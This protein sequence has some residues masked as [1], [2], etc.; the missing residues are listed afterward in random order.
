MPYPL[1]GGADAVARVV[2]QSLSERINA[3]VIVENR[4][5]AATNL[6]TDAT[7]RATPDGYTIRSRHQQSGDQPAALSEQYRGAGTGLKMAVTSF[8]R[9]RLIGFL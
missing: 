9:S 7:A 6:G 5:G 3:A 1:G 2:S 8:D 4:P